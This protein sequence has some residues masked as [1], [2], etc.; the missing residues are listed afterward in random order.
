MTETAT[1]RSGIGPLLSGVFLLMAA[2]G[3]L[4]TSVA[5]R[6]AQKFGSSALAGIV[7]SAYFCGL[8]I[9][10]LQLGRIV[11]RVG[12]IRAFAAFS[13]LLAAASVAHIVLPEGWSWIVLRLLQGLSMAGLFM[14][15]ESWLNQMADPQQRG[16]L[17]SFYMIA[18]YGGTGVGQLLLTVA[19]PGSGRLL[20]ISALLMS[21]AAVPIVLMRSASPS[22]PKFTR[23]GIRRLYGISPLGVALTVVSGLVMGALYGVAPVFAKAAGLSLNQI[24][25][26]MAG[27][28]LGGFALQFPIGRLSDRLDRR[29]VIALL[30]AA[31]ALISLLMMP[32]MG[33]GGAPLIVAGI[34]L[35]GVAFTLYPLAVAHVND[36]IHSDTMLAASASVLLIYSIGAAIG[37]IISAEFMS[38]WGAPGFLIY[39][40]VV[41]V[42]AAVFSVARI[43]LGVKIPM[44]M[45]GAYVSVP[46]TSPIATT[47]DP[48]PPEPPS[49]DAATSSAN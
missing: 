30:T 26:F 29:H 28:M 14:C 4:H 17:L 32:L 8:T 33:S 43:M 22:L 47:I 11:E 38:V 45:Q 6:I 49:R 19:S 10:A 24:S 18:V 20:A 3:L 25:L 9:G 44:K 5:L 48:K 31:L 27:L 42:A 23:L 35:G 15:V 12:H 7:M 40:A 1:P 46:R 13:S 39:L 16:R 2:L 36:F 21:L 34:A 37:P 41:G